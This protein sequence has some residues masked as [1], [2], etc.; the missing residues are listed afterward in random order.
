MKS[1]A[2]NRKAVT[3]RHAAL[4][5]AGVIFVIALGFGGWRQY[6]QYTYEHGPLPQV[7]SDAKKSALQRYPYL[8][9][10]PYAIAWGEGGFLPYGITG[11]S[12]GVSATDTASI[13]FATPHEKDVQ[14]VVDIIA[15]RLTQ[16][17][18]KHV[19]NPHANVTRTFAK[20]GGYYERNDAVCLL[21]NFAVYLDCTNKT[22]LAA[23]ASH[24]QP[25]ATLYMDYV[26]AHYNEP[27]APNDPHR[28]DSF[29]AN[30]G[31]Y[32]HPY[33]GEPIL[34]P[35]SA[36]GYIY[37][38]VPIGDLDEYPTVQEPTVAYFYTDA[39]G[40]NW[41]YLYS[42]TP[43]GTIPC[44]GLSPDAAAAFADVCKP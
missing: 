10:D 16:S 32:A 31:L 3:L 11:K 5:G 1:H 39:S 41:H 25:F 15:S 30:N 42:Y 14:Q 22:A 8:K 43:H 26:S 20:N 18:F 35:G 9:T 36:R 6:K 24:V 40:T 33:F 37:A 12:Y 7:V 27:S 17:G 13:F 4:L 19:D 21:D 34:N 29:N 2:R 28:K 23:V 38:E 44:K